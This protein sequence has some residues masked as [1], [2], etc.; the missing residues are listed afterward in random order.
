MNK[1]DG[2]CCLTHRPGQ[3]N[4]PIIKDCG[5][6]ATPTGLPDRT[7]NNYR[8]V[9]R[10]TPLQDDPVRIVSSIVIEPAV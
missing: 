10:S 1:R 8:G 6:L 3:R 9:S 4:T 7:V 2:N 5:T